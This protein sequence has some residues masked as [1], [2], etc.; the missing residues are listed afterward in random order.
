MTTPESLTALADRARALHP[1]WDDYEPLIQ[2][3]ILEKLAA[4][5]RARAADMQA[6]SRSHPSRS[7]TEVST[8]E[9]R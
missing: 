2:H 9:P 1:H 6:R 7:A 5:L 8:N 4:S 3:M